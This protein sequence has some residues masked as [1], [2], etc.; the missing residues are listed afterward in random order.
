MKMNG[1]IKRCAL[2]LGL[3]VML[4]SGTAGAYDLR[5]HF[6]LYDGRFWNFKDSSV[7]E[8]TTWTV[9]GKL[10]LK[11]VGRAFVMALDNGRFLCLREDW[12]GVHIY[13][14]YSAEGF[15]IPETPLLF[16]PSTLKP[17]EPIEQTVTFRLFSDPEHNINYKE[18]G[19][20]NQSIRFISKELEDVTISGTVFK[21]CAVVEK[22]TTEQQNSTSE[23]LYLAPGIGP[24]KRIVTKGNETQVYTVTAHATG[25]QPITAAVPIKEVMP[26]APGITWT[27]RDPQGA[28]WKTITKNKEQVGGTETL[29]FFEDNGDITNYSLTP[30]GMALHRRLYAQWGGCTEFH[31]PNSPLVIL[32]AVI[33]LGAYHSSISNAN[34]HTWPSLTLL[35]EFYPETHSASIAVLK[36]DVTV[37][38]GTYRDCLKVCLLNLS[39]NFNMNS[40]QLCIG[41]V[42]LA[43]D[44]GVIKKRLIDMT[45][46]FNPQRNNRI[47]SVK[48]WDLQSIE[49][50]GK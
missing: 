18:T 31:P 24:I 46:F 23:T 25:G 48:F 43:K 17:G 21:N 28:I 44:T 3:L 11:D 26:F 35:D 36:E 2:T 42:W 32:P 16:L 4:I 6:P 45:N 7:G 37:P 50:Q 10:T 27:Y 33:Q 19:T 15:R 47:N 29:P 39:R 12:E 9:N 30:A 40:E 1:R 49:K 38:A 14:D 22:T 41:Y 5:G 34:V 8:T 13:G 20:I